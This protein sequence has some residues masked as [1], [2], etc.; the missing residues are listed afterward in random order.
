[1]LSEV[2][3]LTRTREETPD[4]KTVLGEVGY[5]ACPNCG[6]QRVRWR[7]RRFYDVVFTWLAAGILS[8]GVY[9]QYDEALW[10]QPY[11]YNEAVLND[12]LWITPRRYWKCRDC[13][14]RG[15]EY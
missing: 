8:S 4:A 15:E 11:E 10:P 12:G 5:D 13:E 6:S 2:E 14:R 3:L 1:M 9:S 7:K